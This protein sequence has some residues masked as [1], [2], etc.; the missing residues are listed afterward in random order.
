MRHSPIW[1]TVPCVSQ[2]GHKIA[3]KGT[4]CILCGVRNTTLQ[5]HFSGRSATA[6]R[7]RFIG[8]EGGWWCFYCTIPLDDTDSSVDHVIPGD[9]GGTN[10]DENLV[11]SCKFCNVEKDNQDVD[12]FRNSEWL[13][14]RQEMVAA[15]RMMDIEVKGWTKI[16]P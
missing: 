3:E 12:V 6:A 2:E 11:L 7:R 13:R 8:K 4:H 14:K 9:K 1:D 5:K 15:I 16:Y 10:E